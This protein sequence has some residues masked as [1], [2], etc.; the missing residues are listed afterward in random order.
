MT[1]AR[2]LLAALLPLPVLAL[3]PAPAVA[4]RAGGPA[5]VVDGTGQPLGPVVGVVGAEI[6]GVALAV[7]DRV[8]LVGVTRDRFVSPLLPV[9]YES[10]DCSGAPLMPAVLALAPFVP[11]LEPTVLGPGPTLLVADGP[12]QMKT[13]H[14][15]WTEGPASGFCSPEPGGLPLQVRETAPLLDLGTIPGPFRLR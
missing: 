12:L 8:V 11:F 6:A 1:R 2:R 5:V 15:L 13:V 9:A 10:L 14:S 3:A 4:F 7:A